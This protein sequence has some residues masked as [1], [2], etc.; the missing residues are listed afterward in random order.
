MSKKILI[1]SLASILVIP[2][3]ISNGYW[4]DFSIPVVIIA[5]PAAVL[6]FIKSKGKESMLLLLAIF[7]SLIA[8]LTVSATSANV[9][10]RPI[11]SLVYFFAPVTFYFLARRVITN[12]KQF[13][14]LL[15]SCL[16]AGACL[17][18]SLVVSVFISG[19]G[20]V[21][22]AGTLN[23][24]FFFLPLTG[25]YGI[26]SLTA[27]YFLVATVIFYYLLVEKISKLEFSLGAI[28]LAILLYF[29]ILSLSRETLL[30]II[31]TGIFSLFRYFKFR[32]ALFLATLICVASG[33]SI[34]SMFDEN[35]SWAVKVAQTIA[36]DNLNELSSGRFELQQIALRQVMELPITGTGFYGFEL[37][38]TTS[39]SYESLSGWSPH[40]YYLTTIW[41]M[42]LIAALF[43]F[44]FFF[45]ILRDSFLFS[46]IYYSKSSKFY[47]VAMFSFLF[48]INLL[49]DAML[50]ASVMGLLSFFVGSMRL[51]AP[52]NTDAE[53]LVLP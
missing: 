1:G 18:F 24:N 52:L 28:T 2:I 21:R 16:I 44:I 25:A 15:K 39:E 7:T 35:S 51:R 53:S 50:A 19:D 4:Q 6:A 26:H 29:M 9:S 8:I 13:L 47:F 32:N 48:I 12:N 38:Y 33:F 37:N 40:L 34:Y 10:L 5:M 41:K 14:F 30:A 20:S 46:N 27:H 49:W 23:G 45:F 3:D 11:G 17:A 42:G 36:A 22:E 31:V 43:Y